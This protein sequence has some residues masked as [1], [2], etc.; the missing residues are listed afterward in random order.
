MLW[1]GVLCGRF[2]PG[3]I[4][5]LRGRARL[6]AALE[7]P[8]QRWVQ[9]W[10]QIDC[11]TW[12]RPATS[13]RPLRHF[14]QAA[15]HASGGSCLPGLTPGA[16]SAASPRKKK[17]KSA[18]R[19]SRPRRGATSLGPTPPAGAPPRPPTGPLGVS[20]TAP[21]RLASGWTP[22]AGGAGRQV[23]RRKCKS[24]PASDARRRAQE[25]RRQLRPSPTLRTGTTPVPS[26]PWPSGACTTAA[27][28]L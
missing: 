21:E 4:A 22:E 2:F 18:K 24:T 23:G 15:R 28:P 12:A 5:L 14:V 7:L 6:R 19:P 11:A 27:P 17:G 10:V 9:R 25:R 3:L 1:P 20:V 26:P 8:E 13:M 16:A